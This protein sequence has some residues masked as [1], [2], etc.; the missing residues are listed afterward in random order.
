LLVVTARTGRRGSC[1]PRQRGVGRG[2]LLGISV[3]GG[4]V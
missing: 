1:G 2:R 4:L 3:P